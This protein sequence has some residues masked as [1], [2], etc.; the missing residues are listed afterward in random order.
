MFE[1]PTRVRW[2]VV[3]L[4]AGLAF[5]AHFNRVSIS[6]AAK[7]HFIGPGLLT[8][9]QMGLVYSAFLFVYTLGM[10]P[11]GYLLDRAGP[12]RA[13][14]VMAVGLGSWAALTGVLGWSGLGVAAMFVPLLLIRGLAG[15]TSVPLHPGAARA[16]SLWVP[17]GERSTA[18]GTVTAGALVGIALTYPVFGWLM[19]VVGWPAAFVVSGAALALL[20]VGWYALAADSPAEHP[21]TNAA[22]REL[23]AAGG[24]PPP[25]AAAT[26]ADVADLLRNRSLVLLTLSYGA[27][28]YMQ[29]LF[30]YWIEFYFGSELKLPESE[31]RRAAFV[32][33]MA[34]AVGMALGGWVADRL[35]RAL[36]PRAGNRVVAVTGMSLSAAFSL[37]GVAAT[38]P[39]AVVAWFA[40]GLGALG[41]CEGVFWTT[42][43][44]LAPRNGGLACALVNTGGNGVG[45]LAPVVTPVIG[46]AVGWTT[47]VGVACGVCFV[48]GLLWFAVSDGGRGRA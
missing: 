34:S 31:S 48:G 29:Y 1:R 9:A 4:L 32:V 47:A 35:G 28:G 10:L 37:C 38:N 24:A 11:G 13:M 44:A 45:L 23:V 27:L 5:L 22:E 26:L 42:A 8:A 20:G 30:F 14:T 43:P 41:L 16:V 19:D 21:G 12:R 7:A 39:D 40:L 2:L 36:G 15:A 17:P 25:R 46:E 3:A 6:V 33:M 18:N